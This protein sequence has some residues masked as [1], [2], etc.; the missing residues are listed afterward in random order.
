MTFQEI[1]DGVMKVAE[2]YGQRFGLVLDQDFAFFKLH[3]EVGEF[4]KAVLIHRKRS[5]PEKLVTDQESKE[6][7]ASELADIVGLAIIN[8]RL[9]GIDLQ[10]AIQ[11]KWLSNIADC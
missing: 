7:L 4:A 2:T 3:E 6:M 1:E 9:L 11:D 5:R 10:K 8:A